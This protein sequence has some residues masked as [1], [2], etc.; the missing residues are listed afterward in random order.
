MLR[1]LALLAVAA[2]AADATGSVT[3][4]GSVRPAAAVDI[5]FR[6]GARVEVAKSSADGKYRIVMPAGTYRVAVRDDAWMTV[7]ERELQRLPGLPSAAAAGAPDESAM[8]E[9]VVT[10]DAEDVDI[11]IVRS[12]IVTGTVLDVDD[13]AIS[14]AVVSAHGVAPTRALPRPAY[15]TD[16]AVSRADGSF[17]L[18]LP[19]GEYQLAATHAAFADSV[20]VGRVEVR[21]GTR[22]VSLTL[23]KGCIVSG[24]VLAADGK[25]AGEGAIEKRFGTTDV[26]FAP[27]GRIEPDGTFRWTTLDEREVVLRVWPWHSPPSPS[28]PFACRDGA[29]FTTTFTLPSRAPDLSGELVDRAGNPQ[30]FVHL[31]VQP[32]D[33]GGLAQQERTDANGRWAVFEMPPGR[34]AISARAP[35]GVVST[36]VTAPSSN[37][38]LELSGTGRLAGTTT[39]LANG[40]FELALGT[41][42]DRDIRRISTSKR[43]VI[44]RGGQFFVAGVPACDLQIQAS[45]RDQAATARATVPANGVARV[46]LDLGPPRDKLVLGRVRDAGGKPASRAHVIAR[47]KQRVTTAIA[48]EDGRFTI[49]TFA[50]ATLDAE[51]DGAR[52]TG[53]VGLANLARERVDIVLSRR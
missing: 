38:K 41:C 18:R 19:D 30:P 20:D 14:G 2:C 40:S 15:G 44:V 11:A 24:R 28:K 3:I 16:V 7:G 37:T 31:D 49:E 46:Q 33:P 9:L 45:W 23:V 42:F 12:G 34:Y 4:T 51:H 36:V 32:L 53:E 8:P 6:S 25:P 1:A 35:G 47:Y 5:V 22:H 10:H 43:L 48:D 29:R 13:R 17:E 21:G 26:E 39:N 50:G 27:N 52:G